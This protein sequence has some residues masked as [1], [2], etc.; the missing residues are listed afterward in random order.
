MKRILALLFA[1]TFICLS[2]IS[3]SADSAKFE[4]AW[5]LYK[6]WNGDEPSE[7]CGIWL[8]D[9]ETASL[10]FGIRD[11]TAG[12][13]LREMIL[14][15]VEN[16]ESVNFVTQKYLKSELLE[17]KEKVN[18]YISKNIGIEATYLDEKRNRVEICVL[19]ERVNDRTT[20]SIVKT[21]EEKYGDRVNITYEGDMFKQTI[22]AVGNG[23]AGNGASK[24]GSTRFIILVICVIIVLLASGYMVIMTK[25][26]Q[27]I[28]WAEKHGFKSSEESKK[29]ENITEAK[30]DSPVGTDSDDPSEDTQPETSENSENPEENE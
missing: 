1:L 16:K 13:A 14:E 30:K 17:I 21:I 24:W 5:E 9:D 8:T 15:S 2:A 6:S 25:R 27:L 4:D 18:E 11:D 20:Q 29:N 12:E 7:I 10:T 23:G 19:A 22:L 28:E 3:V 26:G